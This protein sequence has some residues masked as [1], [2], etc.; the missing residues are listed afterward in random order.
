MSE[1]V[2][3]DLRKLADRARGDIAIANPVAFLIRLMGG[4]EMDGEKLDI[5]GRM[6]VAKFLAGRWLP[7]LQAMELS[8]PN[9]NSLL[10][11][12]LVIQLAVSK[13]DLKDVTEAGMRMEERVEHSIIDAI[14]SPV[15]EP[16]P[17]II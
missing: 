9:G 5:R 16:D 6:D 8:D 17:V 2:R 15:E 1:A 3:V 13:N 10:P 14:S 7:Q 11:P 12:P 4:E